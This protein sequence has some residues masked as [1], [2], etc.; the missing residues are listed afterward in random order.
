MQGAT[1]SEL[2]F[3]ELSLKAQA[4]LRER[5]LKTFTKSSAF[6]PLAPGTSTG[7]K[8]RVE[9]QRVLHPDKAMPWLDGTSYFDFI[10]M[11]FEVPLCDGG[12]TA[13]C[14]SLNQV[15]DITSQRA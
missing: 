2:P 12:P 3:S 6:S 5:E 7:M 4:T 11:T 8:E 13:F 1:S 15:C 10:G 14:A 9:R